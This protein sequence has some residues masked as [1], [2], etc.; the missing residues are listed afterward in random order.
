IYFSGNAGVGDAR[1]KK[2]QK[3]KTVRAGCLPPKAQLARAGRCSLHPG[4]LVES[5]RTTSSGGN[6]VLAHCRLSEPGRIAARGPNPPGL[7]KG[8]RERSQ[9][10]DGQ[11]CS[12]GG[13]AKGVADPHRV[14]PGIV[15]GLNVADRKGA[16]R[17]AADPAA[18]AKIGAIFLP[19]V[20]Q[21]RGTGRI[22]CEH[23]ISS[24]QNSLRGKC[25][26]N[27]CH[28]RCKANSFE[29]CG[30]ECELSITAVMI[31]PL[32]HMSACRHVEG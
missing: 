27:T 28:I 5:E 1:D 24:L 11:G 12:T 8:C 15:I 3:V 30:A 22:D 31:R 29:P 16:A 32:Q 21:W 9:S 14:Y 23:H 19:L 2:L 18:V 17:R 10:D 6:S 13:R 4:A 7:I 25:V 20:G 26:V